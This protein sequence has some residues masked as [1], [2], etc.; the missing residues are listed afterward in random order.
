MIVRRPPAE[1][2]IGYYLVK[3]ATY[4]SYSS[5]VS[6]S[7]TLDRAESLLP[8]SYTREAHITGKLEENQTHQKI[9]QRSL[10][11]YQI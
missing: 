11:V 2:N 4:K 7:H 8:N 1:N 6:E 5:V 9:S 3:H 10:A